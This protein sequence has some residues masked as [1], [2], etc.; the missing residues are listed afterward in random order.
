MHRSP[1]PS[2][3]PRPSSGPSRRRTHRFSAVVALLATVLASLATVV[4]S[5]TP[6]GAVPV[7][8]VF[9][10]TVT[11]TANGTSAPVTLIVSSR[12]PNRSIVDIA[13]TLRLNPNASQQLTV[14]CGAFGGVK[15][16][17]INQT[18]SGGSGGVPSAS[19]VST[20]TISAS[21]TM[22]WAMVPVVGNLNVGIT[23]TASLTADRGAMIGGTVRLGM[24]GTCFP[25]LGV[26]LSLTA[27]SDAPYAIRTRHDGTTLGGID[28][29]H[30]IDREPASASVPW[31][32]NPCMFL[33]AVVTDP[34]AIPATGLA[35]WEVLAGG[36]PGA[37][38]KPGW[39]HGDPTGDVR[40]TQLCIT[41]QT[42]A[43]SLIMVTFRPNGT[44]TEGQVTIWV[45]DNVAYVGR[46][47]GDV[48]NTTFDEVRYDF[49]GVGEYVDAMADAGSGSTPKD[50][51]VQSR[52]EAVPS[53]PVTVT[54]AVAAL[55]NGDRVTVS[56]DAS[57]AVGWRVNGRPVRRFPA[58]LPG[59]G[60]LASPTPDHW[61]ITWADNGT[62]PGTTTDTTMQVSLARWTPK[63]HL[64]I[65]ELRLGYGLGHGGEVA[66]M[67]GSPDRDGTNDL[68][69]SWGGP[70]VSPV[71]DPNRPAYE[72]PLY[73]ELGRSW[74][75]TG[76][77]SGDP[78]ASMFDYLDPAHPDPGS[79]VDE[80]YPVERPGVVDREAREACVKAGV[81]AH[82]QLDF[83][84]YDV[85]VTGARDIAAYY[86]DGW[87]P[88]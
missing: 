52:L 17:A 61:R 83:C 43:D 41:D 60:T 8:A 5:P 84:T 28:L 2:P 4:A 72:Q 54:T 33:D 81:T 34:A 37:H 58:R 39:S 86:A 78:Q 85:E 40:T 87:L 6:A 47:Q 74:L 77:G 68:T 21:G 88:V 75:V 76:A 3:R 31:E 9:T 53:A 49:Q 71:L 32:R 35:T 18:L 80:K 48:H 57:G 13:A 66:G 69:P 55:V 25:D 30:M 65:D 12:G 51:M 64:N 73:T 10:G 26:T 11:N 56:L 63:D 44:F 22:T 82:P 38:I 45:N 59:G 46:G 27:M 24:P 16:P 20:P 79:Y 1:P 15:V 36:P 50:F 23:V 67:F 29:T 70:P 42:P 19:P 62:G 7:D 14:S